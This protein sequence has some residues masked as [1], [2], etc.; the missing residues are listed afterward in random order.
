MQ[1]TEG[2]KVWIVDIAGLD[3]SKEIE[4]YKANNIDFLLSTEE[5]WEKDLELFGEN[6]DVVVAEASISVDETFIEQL[7]KCKA[8]LSFG[9]GFN[10]IDIEAAKK[11][12]ITVC[13][14][15]DY[16][17]DE[18]ADHTLSLILMLLRRV[19]DYNKNLKSGNW[20]SISVKPLHRFQNTTIGLLG[21]GKIAQKVADRLNPFGFTIIAHD[22]YVDENVFREKKV[23][24]ASLEELFERSNLISLHVPL[25]NETSNL[26]NEANMRKLPKHAM[27]V[28]TC[29]G[30]I[31]DE[32]ALVQ[33]LKEEHLSGAGL[34][35]FL[36]ES[37]NNKHELFTMEEIIVTPHAAYY[38]IESVEEMQT[39]TAE[40]GI[41]VIRNKKPLYIVN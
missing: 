10:H 18:V 12:N 31:I 28:N 21:F 33:L 8:I 9:T 39:K 35:V 19:K 1:S 3:H 6:A 11:R 17:S 5:T 7:T 27:I 32:D 38:S 26:L 16:C 14:L 2:K 30:G 29:R 13:N 25:T 4:I 37:P 40:N 22:Q 15:P 20:N 36:F 41:N 23:V 24:S 34:D